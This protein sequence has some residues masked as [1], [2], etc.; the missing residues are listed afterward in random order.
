MKIYKTK[1]IAEIIEIPEYV[2]LDL[3]RIIYVK[4][5]RPFNQYRITDVQL[6]ALQTLIDEARMLF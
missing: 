4:K 1:E 5:S 3:F 2:V 6:K